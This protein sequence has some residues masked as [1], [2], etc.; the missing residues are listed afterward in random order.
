MT[1]VLGIHKTVWEEGAADRALADAILRRE[2]AGGG[3]DVAN[4]GG[5]HSEPDVHVW[6]EA[7]E[8]LGRIRQ[9]AEAIG[10]GALRV[11]AWANV[12]RKGAY[13][14]A[15]RHGEAVWS[16][17]YYVDAGDGAGGG[18]QFAKGGASCTLE[19]Q[20]GLL[21]I[22]PGDL[23]HDVGEYRGDGVRISVAFNLF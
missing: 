19:P 10:A 7:S 21:L 6:P 16:G 11:H 2:A 18:V 14:L 4:V 20:R 3:L 5:W 22:F 8:L 9:R 13:V 23:L 17:V 15:H 12:M 1:S